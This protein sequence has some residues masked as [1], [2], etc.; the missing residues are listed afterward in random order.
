MA[1]KSSSKEKELQSKCQAAGAETCGRVDAYFEQAGEE[2]TVATI[3]SSIVVPVAR[4]TREKH[5]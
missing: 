1:A 2:H 4:W 5:I 3:V